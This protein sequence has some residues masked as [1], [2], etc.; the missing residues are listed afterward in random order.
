[1]K[2]LVLAVATLL[3]LLLPTVAYAD[4]PYN[5]LQSACGSGGGVGGS[6][7]CTSDGSDPITGKNGILKKASL[8]LATIAGITAV[9]IIIVG[10]FRYITSG[11]DSAKAASARNAIIGAVVGLVIIAAA[12]TLVVFVVNRI[13]K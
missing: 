7:A 11:G 3:C 8:V 10:G 6:S 13:A 2:R 5:P 12:E 1:M 9:I 4:D